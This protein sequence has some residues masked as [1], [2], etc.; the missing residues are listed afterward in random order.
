[1]LVRVAVDV[2]EG[3]AQHHRMRSLRSAAVGSAGAGDQRLVRDL[4]IR[5]HALAQVGDG[6]REVAGR[7]RRL[8]T[9]PGQPYGRRAVLAAGHL[10]GVV[11]TPEQ[12]W[13][14]LKHISEHTDIKLREVA[15]TL[16]RWPAPRRPAPAHRPC[17]PAVRRDTV[18][19][20]VPRRACRSW[21]RAR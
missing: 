9:V 18:F 11:I 15:D 3:P 16:V 7:G 20:A 10:V 4:R 13:A 14:A 6:A 17:R 8:R 1:M 21:R 2:G 12:G 19:G 5:Q